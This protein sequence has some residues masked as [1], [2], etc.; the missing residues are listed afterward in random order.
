MTDTRSRLRLEKTE[1]VGGRGMVVT[2]HPEA[3]RVG[4]EILQAGGNVADAAVAAAFALSVV[5]PWSSGLGGGGYAVVARGAEIEVIAFPMQS[6]AQATPQRYPR[7]GRSNVGGF[8]WDGVVNDANLQG[9]DSMSVPGAVAGFA[10]LAERHGTMP[11]DELIEPAR[12]LAR[13]GFDLTWFDGLVMGRGAAAA[14]RHPSLARVFYPDGGVQRPEPG[15]AARLEQ[16]ELADTLESLARD[17]PDAFYR[18]DIAAAVAADC[19]AHGGVLQRDD[20][21]QYQ[22][23]VR[24][25]MQLRYGGHTV[26]TPG[27]GC[28]GPTTQQTLAI[29]G[30]TDAA[31]LD[32]ASADR[33]HTFMWAAR[34][35]QADRFEFMADPDRH[36]APWS[37][38]VAKDYARERAAVIDPHT[39][40]VD[41]QPGEAWA[42]AQD[43]RATA[44][45]KSETSTTHLC[46]AD[47]DGGFVSLTNTVGGAW[48][49][50]VIPGRTGVVWNDGMWWFDPRPGRPNSVA[51]RSFG[52]NNMTPAIVSWNAQ[53]MLAVG[54]SGG[55][56]I[57]NCVA[58]LVTHVVDCDMSA[59]AALDA[60]R[61]DA[62]T[63]WITLDGRFGEQIAEDLRARGWDVRLPP[64]PEQSAFASPVAILRAADGS[65]RGGADTFHSAEARG[66]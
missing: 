13:G 48:G 5:E 15:S 56:R 47:A 55:R 2:K 38:M 36:E 44:R 11:W 65:L 18:G 21:A 14:Q 30:Q 51:P 32:Q 53:P 37:A 59:Q 31:G 50:E 16:P 23:H 58:Q 3:S 6:G 28:A 22:A 61:V 34:L 26:S 9:W 41:V 66:W 12:G 49:A 24:A 54:A 42:Y 27:A 52:L 39:A 46:V 19:A 64:Y 1:A 33:L 62:S 29:F 45:Q 7:D 10:L 35:A 20:L 17:G 63:P 43:E 8:L 60:P 40:P 4:L 57:T 25:P